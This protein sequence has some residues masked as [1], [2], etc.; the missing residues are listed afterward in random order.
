LSTKSS[1]SRCRSK[2]EIRD[3]RMNYGKEARVS[4]TPRSLKAAVP[5]FTL[6][7]A[8]IDNNTGHEIQ[9]LFVS[10]ATRTHGESTS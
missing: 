9:Y 1:R 3:F 2:F 8:H 4:L 7:T 6:A 10:P 5:N